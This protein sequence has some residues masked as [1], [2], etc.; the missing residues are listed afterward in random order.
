MT[1]NSTPLPKQNTWIVMAGVFTLLALMIAGWTLNR[2]ET[3][4]RREVGDSLQTVLKTTHVALKIWTS[5]QKEDIS[6][7]ILSHELRDAVQAQLAAPRNPQ[8]LLASPALKKLRS[9]LKPT[10]VSNQYQGFFIIAPDFINIASMRDSN[11]GTKNLLVGYENFLP[12]IF[13][14]EVLVSHPLVSDVPLPD[15]AGE[16]R[17]DEPTLFVAAP[18]MDDAGTVMAVLAFRID[19]AKAFTRITQFGRF[20]KTGETYL[21]NRQGQMLSDSRFNDQLRAAGLL[22]PGKRAILNIEIRDPGGNMVEGFHPSTTRNKQPLT[23]MAAQAVTGQSGMNLDGYRDYRGVPV[24]GAWIWDAKLDLG[25]A[26]EINVAEAYRLYKLTERLL[27]LAGILVIGLYIGLLIGMARSQIQTLRAAEKMRDSQARTKAVLDNIVDGIITIDEKGVIKSFNP[28]AERIFGYGAD[29]VINR[30]INI[31]MPE[32]DA[33]E[34][35]QYIRDYLRTGKA[36]IIGFGREVTGRRRDGSTFPLDLAVSETQ[37]HGQRIFMGVLRDITNRKAMEKKLES[38]TKNLEETVAKRTSDLHAALE[39]VQQAKDRID[40]ILKSIGDGLLVTDAQNRVILMNPAAEKILGVS[41]DK[42]LHQPIDLAIQQKTLREQVKW[43]LDKRVPGYQFDFELPGTAKNHLRIMQAHTSII[44]D[45]AGKE[46]GIVIIMYDVTQEREM[47]Q[48]KTEFI[49]TAAHELRTPLTTIQGF[50]EL[51][52]T[53]RNLDPEKEHR[54]LSHINRQA[55][56][57]ANIISDLLDISRIESGRGF[58][59]NKARH[60]IGGILSQIVS[61]FQEHSDKHRFEVILPPKPLMGMLDEQKI[62]QVIENLLSNAVKYSPDGGLIQ[63]SAE[64]REDGLRITVKDEGIGMTPQ[65]T[66]KI[67]DKFYRVDASNT[68]VEGTGLG[69]TIVRHIVNAHG[70]KVSVESRLGK[71]TTVKFTLPEQVELQTEEVLESDA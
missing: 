40:G 22:A 29:E 12:R 66:A 63:V 47:D 50:A 43:V 71:G 59:L 56:H 18:I 19:P 6:H 68:A 38:H 24:V 41:L 53:W 10:V 21:F 20:G 62:H 52:M 39:S 58:S 51:L 26:A 64:P 44:L 8:T 65:Q 54:F 17:E 27:I 42:A 13:N 23:S 9:L 57:L 45:K 60:D 2:I 4:T 7:W 49:S 48:M 25:L 1:N 37:S 11:V 28:A 3:Q 33:S 46:I 34:H 5:D 31:L 70:G 16:L 32:P 67:F 36:K 55:E 15:I 30:N 35:D 61:R 69:M 14:G